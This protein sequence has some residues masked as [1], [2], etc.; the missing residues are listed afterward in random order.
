MVK[1]Y[2]LTIEQILYKISYVNIIMLSATTPDYSRKKDDKKNSVTIRADDPSNND[3]I[4]MMIEGG[5]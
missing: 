2:N 1:N 5:L 4:R 3:M